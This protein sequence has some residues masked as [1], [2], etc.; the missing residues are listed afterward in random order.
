M[1]GAQ[2][3]ANRFTSAEVVL[4][5]FD[6]SFPAIPRISFPFVAVCD[7]ARAHILAMEN[8]DKSNGNRYICS[9]KTYPLKEVMGHLAELKSFG[10]KVPSSEMKYCMFSLA[11]LFKAEVKEIK[12]LWGRTIVC[13][14]DKICEELGFEFT[15]VLPQILNMAYE[16]IKR[17][18]IKDKTKGAALERDNFAS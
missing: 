9:E 15:P 11:G 10:Y 14:H 7:V 12:P 3:V 16:C 2:R 17:G 13:H 4:Q 6:G 8:F 1:V 18:L 5:F